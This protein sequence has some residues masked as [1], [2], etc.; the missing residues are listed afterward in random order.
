MG[1]LLLE[2]VVLCLPAI[3]AAYAV[4]GVAVLFL[5][6]STLT[7][8]VH[9][10][11]ELFV[12]FWV[13][14]FPLGYY[15]GSFPRDTP[16]FTFDRL[17]LAVILAATIFAGGRR[18]T[19][20]PIDLRKSATYW[21]VFV[22]FAAISIPRVKAPFSA[23]RVLIEAF[24]FPGVLAWYVIRYIDVRK[25]L[26]LLHLAAALMAICVGSIGVAEVILQRDLLALS[27]SS[28]ILAGDNAD[29]SQLWLRPNGPF[30]STNSFALVGLVTLLFL[31][32]ARHAVS[33][34]LP[35]W[36]KALHYLG[37][38]FALLSSLLPL[39][40]SVLASMIVILIIEAYYSRGFR[41]AVSL[42]I[43]GS[44]FLLVVA[45]RIA[46]PIV[47]EER[48]ASDNLFGRIAEQRQVLMM[49]LDN[50]IN[51]V[52]FTNFTEAAQHSKYTTYF[53][54]VQSVD[55]QHNNLAAVLSE[56]GLSGFVPFVVS[57]VLF[58][59]AFWRL[60]VALARSGMLLWKF[61]L[62]FFAAY[63]VNGMSLTSGYYSDLNLWYM[64]SLA[65]LY[66]F[67]L[68]S[69]NERS[70]FDM[71]RPRRIDAALP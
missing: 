51:G 20:I 32:F 10:R 70:N 11:A 57:Q 61:F 45:I 29:V 2:V 69:P 35:Q 38:V 28:I 62:F 31:L 26:R 63:W 43:I 47:F 23:C 21:A 41:R 68:V 42:L 19:T 53:R 48:S 9:G 40:R 52:G 56:D 27:S 6:F 59:V 5:S 46:M 15:F 18:A 34:K 64:F 16:L 67:G 1:F 7:A 24:V 13:A 22:F 55:A 60:R 54:G 66:K 39:F 4:L 3:Y 50:P 36:Q 65:V 58:V 33:E 44:A 30:S 49:F 8:V 17:L 14:L 37:V 25:N 12:V 71:P